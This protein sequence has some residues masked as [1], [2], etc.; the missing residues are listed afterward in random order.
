MAPRSELLT[1][2]M[3]SIYEMEC[4]EQPTRLASLLDTYQTPAI[5]E[6]LD[7]L[8]NMSLSAGPV[9]FIGMGAS[10][11]SSIS[12]YSYLQSCGRTSFTADAGEWLHYSRAWEQVALSLL[13]TTSGESAELVQLCRMGAQR[14]LALL[15]NNEKSA[16][17]SLVQN[18]LPI[19]AGPEYGNA[20]KTYANA[21]AAGIVMASHIAG[22]EW[23]EDAARVLRSY[24]AALD[25]V[26]GLRNEMEE[27]C[28]GAA[29][30]EVIGRGPAYG[31]AIMG[32][33]CIREMTGQR[34]APHSGG[35]LP[36]WASTRR[37]RL[38]RRDHP[39]AGQN[40]GSRSFA[41]AGLSGAWRKSHP[42]RDRGTSTLRE[43]VA[44]KD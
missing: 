34:A 44:D 19:L 33:L 11:C 20:T 25:H 28:R 18:R 4:R 14:P 23:Q 27:F 13:V 31:G 42:R 21:T 1:Q 24:P 9:L 5:R 26:F 2:S 22:R 38:S 39:G 36:P 6:E 35:G 43:T 17:W 32:A 16:C 10:Y 37:Q 40:C 12:D 41:L 7:K 3:N 29:N 8:R 30:I 15:C